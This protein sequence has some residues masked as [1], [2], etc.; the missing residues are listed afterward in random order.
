MVTCKDNVKNPGEF[1]VK[2]NCEDS[3]G[4]RKGGREVVTETEGDGESDK[5][6]GMGQHVMGPQRENKREIEERKGRARLDYSVIQ[7]GD[8]ERWLVRKCPKEW[9]GGRWVSSSDLA[10]THT[11]P[12]LYLH[13]LASE[14]C[15]MLPDAYQFW[16]SFY[17]PNSFHAHKCINVDIAWE[18]KNFKDI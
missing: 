15:S 11:N 10:F 7:Q 17:P 1:G 5:E 14:Q 2:S 16:Q 3:E 8:L 9:E 13:T 6:G 18:A 4:G 12:H